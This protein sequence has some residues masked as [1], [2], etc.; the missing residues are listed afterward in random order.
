M[1]NNVTSPCTRSAVLT[2]LRLLRFRTRWKSQASQGQTCKSTGSMIMKV[3]PR[4]LFSPSPISGSLSTSSGP[5]VP[6]FASQL[7]PHPEELAQC[8]PLGGR[9]RPVGGVKVPFHT[10]WDSSAFRDNFLSSNRTP[11]GSHTESSRQL[12]WLVA[13]TGDIQVEV[14]AND[15]EKL[16]ISGIQYGISLFA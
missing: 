1:C 7:G 2:V 13:A 10:S 12:V 8:P 3:G 5:L 4:P 16:I 11:Q 15:F 9:P 6:N 14:K